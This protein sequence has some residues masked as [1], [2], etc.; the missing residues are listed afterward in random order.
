MTSCRS[1]SRHVPAILFTSSE[2]TTLIPQIETPVNGITPITTFNA[3]GETIT[4]LTRGEAFGIAGVA[5]TDPAGGVND[6]V[7]IELIG[8]QSPRTYVDNAGRGVIA[9][10]EKS[11]SVILRLT[12]VDNDSFDLDLARPI[13]G[14]LVRLWPKAGVDTDT[15]KDG[16]LE[17]TPAAPVLK[18][19]KI[20]VPSTDGAIYKNGATVVTGTTITVAAATTIVATADTGWE[21]KAGATATWTLTPA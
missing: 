2:A 11:R 13:I 5:S 9:S 10:D 17:V 16:L 12:S 21:L 14:D 7:T 4:S 15:D 6:G 8:A 20:T 3:K 1:A 18:G 19:T